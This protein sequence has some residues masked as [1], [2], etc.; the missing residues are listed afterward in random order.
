MHLRTLL[1]GALATLAAAADFEAA[2]AT[3]AAGA[4]RSRQVGG[5]VA[6][7]CQHANYGGLCVDIKR[8]P[9][10]GCFNLLG[11]SDNMISSIKVG[12]AASVAF[13]ADPFCLGKDLLVKAW[14]QDI[15][16]VGDRANDKISAFYV[17]YGDTTCACEYSAG[18]AA[19][20]G[21]PD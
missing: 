16:Y 4:L 21:V 8:V 10:S 18:G 5:T 15:G 11:R 7:Y 9:A 6:T 13:Y 14:N 19:V 12:K 17:S 20:G 2:N 1:A 3:E